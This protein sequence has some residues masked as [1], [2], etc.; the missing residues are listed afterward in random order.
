MVAAL[1]DLNLGV[2]DSFPL[3][4]VTLQLNP[5]QFFSSELSPQSSS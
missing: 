2:Y 4:S 1:A 3:I 5:E